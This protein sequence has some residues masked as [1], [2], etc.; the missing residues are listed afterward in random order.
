MW[1]LRVVICMMAG[2]SLVACGDSDGTNDG[3]SGCT[4]GSECASGVCDE[5]TGECA[6]AACDDGIL[7]GDET[8]ADCG[9]S[10][11]ACADGDS[12]IEPSDCE[13]GVCADKMCAVPSCGDG[14]SNQAV[15]TCDD[16]GESATCDVDCTAAE[17]GD[18]VLNASADEECDGAGES[19]VCNLDCTAAACGD[20]VL[21]VSA[22]EEC[23]DGNLDDTDFCSN[24]CVLA[25]CTDEVQNGDESDIDCG[26]ACGPGSCD[27]GQICGGNA[28]CVSGS[29]QK[30]LCLAITDFPMA[31]GF[32]RTCA[33]VSP[34]SIRCWGE[35]DYGQLG[36][37]HTDWIGNNELPSSEPPVDFGAEVLQLSAGGYHTCALLAGGLVYCW[38]RN[39]VGQLGYGNNITIGDDESPL[40]AGPVDV[41]GMAIQI[42]AGQFSTCALLDGGGVTCWGNNNSGEMG[43]GHTDVIGDDELPASAGLVDL[44]GPAVQIAAGSLWACA[45][46]ATGDVRCWGNNFYGN[47]GYGHNDNVGNDELPSS[48][49]PA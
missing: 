14:V 19:A 11:A 10:C 7:N 23:D 41:G 31:T 27:A 47:L 25:T 44:G 33:R 38:G 2:L 1:K 26:G 36:Y 18:G 30:G 34:T 45:L 42:S 17:C 4:D 46:M 48:E 28:D 9:G 12:C 29:C 6:L 21:N 32:R 15:E 16:G 43:Y 35:N 40:S 39:D 5:A 22:D 37:G 13:S 8:A 49:E 24:T 3:P 20:G